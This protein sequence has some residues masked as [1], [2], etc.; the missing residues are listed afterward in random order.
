MRRSLEAHARRKK[1]RRSPGQADVRLISRFNSGGEGGSSLD[2]FT[3]QTIQR[4]LLQ[5][6]FGIYLWLGDLNFVAGGHA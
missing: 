6:R 2:A 5:G 3:D 4:N 1:W